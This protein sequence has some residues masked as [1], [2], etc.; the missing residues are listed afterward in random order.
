MLDSGLGLGGLSTEPCSGPIPGRALGRS[1]W[2]AP[3]LRCPAVNRDEKAGAQEE[4]A[5][6]SSRLSPLPGASLLGHSGLSLS[7]LKDPS[8]QSCGLVESEGLGRR[9]C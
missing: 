3:A 8:F 9:G 2:A 7:R 1:C 6:L 4:R 5:V